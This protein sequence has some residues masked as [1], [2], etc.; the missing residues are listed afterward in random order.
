MQFTR[1]KIIRQLVNH[2]DG[3]DRRV[4]H[5][6]RVLHHA[7]DIAAAR[8][9]CDVDIVVAAA[10]LHDV[11]I[12]VAEEKHGHN[13]GRTQEKYGPPVAGELLG[14]IGF[15]PE[16]TGV[17]Q[18]IISNHHSKSRFDYPELE[19]LKQ[20]DGIVNR[21]EKDQAYPA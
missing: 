6:L 10:L 3:D 18:D 16:K 1:A 4:E 12:K 13:T 8:T 2:F 20:A 15:P 11:G 17:V 21:E 7:D 14:A 19:V 9:D 5:A